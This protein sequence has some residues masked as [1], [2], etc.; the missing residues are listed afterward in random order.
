[1][2]VRVVTFTGANDIDAGITFVREKV[3]PMLSAQKGYRGLTASAD[4]DGGV[5]AVLSLW[6]TAADRDANETAMSQTRQDAADIIGG[7]LTVETF[8][9]LVAEIGQPPPGPGSA[10]M[11]TRIS[12]DTTKIDENIA[13]FKNEIVPQIKASAGFQGVRNMMNR[14]T[15]EGI[16]GTAWSDEASRKRAAQEA[17]ARRADAVARG[18][19]FGEVSFREIVL[20]DTR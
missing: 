3:I 9:Q 6:E 8:E 15:G 17:P 10:L 16:V 18:V 11:V 12:M 4:R 7:K 20:A 19:N 1:M 14:T 2:H 13:Y 5:L